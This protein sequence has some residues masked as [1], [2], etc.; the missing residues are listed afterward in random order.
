M[1]ASRITATRVTLGAISLRSSSHFP[2]VLYSNGV[3]PVALP[4]G[5]DNLSTKPAPTG[6]GTY[7]NTIGTVRVACSSGQHADAPRS[8][9]LLRPC[10]ERP[11][12]RRTDE[13]CD[14]LA[15]P[16]VAP[17]KNTPDAKLALAT[18]R[19]PLW[20]RSGHL[21]C[22]TAYPLYPQERTFAVH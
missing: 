17:V 14:E 12:C 10:P 16:H 19:C 22:K 6:S 15:P 4:P 13:N 9:G 1:A 18:P 21:Q 2:L 11:R 5:R 20:V 7:A 3:N 8:L